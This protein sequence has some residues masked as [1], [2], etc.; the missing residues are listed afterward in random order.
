MK[1]VYTDVDLLLL[2]DDKAVLSDQI[3]F[4]IK[5][6]L[7][8]EIYDL[9]TKVDFRR[10]PSNEACTINKNTTHSYYHLAINSSFVR[11]FIEGIDPEDIYEGAEEFK[12]ILALV[13]KYF[14][15]MEKENKH[16]CRIPFD[17]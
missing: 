17:S 1:I 3:R 6:Y 15:S 7:G 9:I 8:K 12:Q 14:T 2:E 16:E 5:Y 11:G 13:K 4:F 10:L